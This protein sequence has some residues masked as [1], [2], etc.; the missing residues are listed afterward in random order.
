VLCFDKET[1]SVLRIFFYFY[2]L[3]DLFRIFLSIVASLKTKNV[4]F[5]LIN[6]AVI[7][8]SIFMSE[9]YKSNFFYSKHISFF[10]SEICNF[11][12]RNSIEQNATGVTGQLNNLI[13]STLIILEST[14]VISTIS[15]EV[16]N[17]RRE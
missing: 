4:I 9:K 12:P 15:A 14:G 10:D 3:P 7:R 16:N 2:F 11:E 1:Q 17:R 5:N 8:I 6:K 13:S